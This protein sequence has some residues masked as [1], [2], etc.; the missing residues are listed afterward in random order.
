MEDQK[1]T[2]QGKKPSGVPMET[3]TP[4]GHEELGANWVSEEKGSQSPPDKL[5]PKKKTQEHKPL[6]PEQPLNPKRNVNS[7]PD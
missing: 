7:R 1:T 6:E 2:K 5:Q 4:I 3:S